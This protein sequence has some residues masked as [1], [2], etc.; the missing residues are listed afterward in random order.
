MCASG[1]T[2]SLFAQKCVSECTVFY[3][4][5]MPLNEQHKDQNL[6]QN[7]ACGT[8]L[9]M[10][11]D[12]EGKST[13]AI[14]KTVWVSACSSYNILGQ[15]DCCVLRQ[16]VGIRN[17]GDFYVYHLLPTDRCPVSYCTQGITEFGLVLPIRTIPHVLNFI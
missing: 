16:R 6:F 2:Q 3:I 13:P 15:W 8:R 12:M 9:P 14:N 1:L 11:I 4:L 10:R 17:C 7:Q 5:I